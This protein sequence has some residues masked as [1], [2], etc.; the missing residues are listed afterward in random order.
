[1]SFNPYHYVRRFLFNMNAEDASVWTLTQLK[2]Y[3][4]NPLL[5]RFLQ[6]S[7]PPLEAEFMGL[8][9]K[10]PVGLAAGLDKNG[11]YIDVLGGLGFGFLEIGTVTPRA[12]AGN[13]RPRLYRLPEH[14]AL[15]NRMGFNNNGLEAFINNIKNCRFQKNGGVLGLNIGKN[16]DT[17]IEEAS[18]DYLICLEGVYPYADYVSINISSP[19]TKN[20]RDLQNSSSLA[21]LLKT[22]HERR[23]ELQKRFHRYVP[24][25]LKIAPDLEYEQIDEI[26]E[27]VMS[28]NIEGVIATNTTISR[29]SISSH[30][31]ASQAG[32]LSG[33]M[34]HQMSIRVIKRLRNLLTSD[35]A[36]IGV[37][38]IQS[39][40]AAKETIDAGANA[41]QIYTGLIYHGPQLVEECL[42]ALRK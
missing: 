1:M 17:P 39:G 36:I 23:L 7:Y 38:G 4:N 40:D 20:L 35:K 42:N 26:A 32:G 11:D 6:K 34:L 8:K 25:A 12:Q 27:L 16:A 15:I 3:S 33:P 13:P 9:V 10:N 24:I 18:S 28:N 22:L 14:S 41:I 19:N 21:E 37:G 5:R 30:E 2:K 29:S 31:F